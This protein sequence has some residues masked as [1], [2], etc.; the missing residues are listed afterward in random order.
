MSALDDLPKLADPED[1][2]PPQKESLLSKY[3]IP[4]Q[5][6]EYD[7]IEKCSDAKELERILQIL[8][9]GEEGYFPHLIKAAEERLAIIK[10]KSG[11]LRKMVPVVN[12]DDLNEHVL[13]EI[14]KDLETWV[15][16]ISKHNKEL[17]K[18]KMNT[19]ECETKVRAYKETA[20]KDKG[21][22]NAEKRIRSTDYPAWDKYDPDT[23][24]LKMDLVEENE[25]RAAIQEKP[26]KNVQKRVSFNKFATE[27]EASY[28][29]EREKE[30]GND[31][32]KA[33]DYEEALQCYTRS[34]LSKPS[35][36]NLNN[37]AV[38][39]VKLKKYRKALE[40]CDRVLAMDSDN[41]KA[42]LRK[43]EALECLEMYEEAMECVNFAIRIDPNNAIAQEL[44]GRVGRRCERHLKNTRMKIVEIE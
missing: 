5:N 4:I 16:D 21:G 25:K 17:E 32:F 15:T 23:E 33:G 14:C 42:R 3:R 36:N 24:I 19:V 35:V 44:A 39:Y 20:D 38:T 12:R 29:A 10:P 43:A 26:R 6:F 28:A 30:K 41:L 40:D 8:R 27:A 34:V 37:R 11:F 22:K 2:R 7:H 9:S 1:Y 18:R 13:D 31:F